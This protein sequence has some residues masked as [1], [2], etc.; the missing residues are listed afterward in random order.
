VAANTVYGTKGTGKDFLSGLKA[1]QKDLDSVAQKMAEA[2]AKEL[3]ESVTGTKGL[4]ATVSQKQAKAYD[5]LE[6]L[7][8][9]ILKSNKSEAVKKAEIKLDITIDKNNKSITAGMA[10][11]VDAQVA[12]WFAS[13]TA[14]KIAKHAAGIVGAA[15]G[16]AWV[17][18]EG[19]ELINLSGGETILSHEQSMAALSRDPSRGYWMGTVGSSPND[20]NMSPNDNSSGNSSGGIEK[21]LDTLIKATRGVGGDV[22][23]NLNSTGRIAGNKASWNNRR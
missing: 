22:A 2:F 1:Q 5:A 20:D 15:S 11:I 18:E 13:H 7:V 9:S 19:A 14:K 23:S 12:L 6:K 16:W 3:S 4:K 8:D 21:R 17:G 10:S